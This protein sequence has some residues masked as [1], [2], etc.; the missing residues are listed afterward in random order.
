[1]SQVTEFANGEYYHIINRGVDGRN[2]FANDADY[3]RFLESLREFNTHDHITIRDLLPR[4]AT[5][6]DSGYTPVE[7]KERLVE[8][9]CYCLLSNHYH[10]AVKQISE[11][12]VT[13]FMRKIGTGYTLYYNKRHEREGR[14]FQN[15]MKVVHINNESHLLHISRYIHLN[16]LDAR[17][18]SWREG[19]MKDWNIAKDHLL[20]YPWSSY[21]IYMGSR[22]SD[23]CEPKEMLELF[24]GKEKYEEFIKEWTGRSLLNLKGFGVA[25][26]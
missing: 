26:E 20:Q 24:G 11:G 19:G 22:E 25:G 15:R 7:E 2:I 5:S 10:L 23:L 8:V 14:L 3:K 17:D 13:E 1:M 12:G 9:L 21:P 18:T 4:G 16:A 6:G